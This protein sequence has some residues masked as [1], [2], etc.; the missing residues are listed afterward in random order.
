M[1]G[2]GR[3]LPE[4]RRD[5]RMAPLVSGRYAQILDKAALRQFGVALDYLYA[6]QLSHSAL[7]DTEIRR[8]ALA[9]TGSW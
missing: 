4:Q 1:D 6:R 5:T 9:L 7:Y 2:D 8:T 3:E